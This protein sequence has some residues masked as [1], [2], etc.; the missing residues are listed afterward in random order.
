MTNP[1]NRADKHG[2]PDMRPTCAT[3]GGNA[4]A[5][6]TSVQFIPPWE[7]V[8]N[9]HRVRGGE[10]YAELQAINVELLAALELMAFGHRHEHQCDCYRQVNDAIAKAKGENYGE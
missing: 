3:V 4:D 7:M 10:T 6:P 9:G 1:F 5:R 2:A 8:E